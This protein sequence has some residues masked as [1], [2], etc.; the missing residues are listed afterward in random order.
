MPASLGGRRCGKLPS[1][2]LAAG[3]FAARTGNRLT[4]ASVR[5]L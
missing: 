1:A 5:G 4:A 3:D 2:K